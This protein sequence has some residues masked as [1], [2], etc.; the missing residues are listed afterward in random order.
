MKWKPIRAAKVP[1]VCTHRQFHRSLSFSEINKPIL[2]LSPPSVPVIR[3]PRGYSHS[4]LV[5]A[6]HI[7]MFWRYSLS[8]RTVNFRPVI[9]KNL[10]SVFIR[11]IQQ[12]TLHNMIQGGRVIR[13]EKVI[14]RRYQACPWRVCPLKSAEYWGEKG[15][16]IRRIPHRE[17][18]KRRE[19]KEDEC[20]KKKD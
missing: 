6:R 2:C 4:T 9:D 18:E 16:G 12:H 5:V 7:V 20:C 14:F 8:F 10:C 19:Q 3:F 1:T 13:E 11:Y 17:E 15:W